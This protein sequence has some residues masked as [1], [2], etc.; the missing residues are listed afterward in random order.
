MVL[1]RLSYDELYN[2]IGLSV[3]SSSSFN[4]WINPIRIIE[5]VTVRLVEWYAGNKASCKY[6][7]YKDQVSRRSVPEPMP[8]VPSSLQL[9][10]TK[11]EDLCTYVYAC[12]YYHVFL[13]RQMGLTGQMGQMGWWISVKSR[14]YVT[15]PVWFSHVDGVSPQHFFHFQQ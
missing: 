12:R 1:C 15:D 11:P 7:K 13:P 10:L 8:T 5:Y 2:P 14:C 4:V 3:H 9:Q 6:T